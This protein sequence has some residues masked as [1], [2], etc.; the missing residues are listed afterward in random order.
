[1]TMSAAAAISGIA[2][3]VLAKEVGPEQFGFYVFGT[4]LAT[5]SLTAV[6]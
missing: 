2:K 3:L 5:L 1:M 6:R 4:T